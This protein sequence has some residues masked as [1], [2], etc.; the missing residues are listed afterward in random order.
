[1]SERIED[2]SQLPLSDNRNKDVCTVE[3]LIGLLDGLLDT[4]R[5]EANKMSS[6]YDFG[7]HGTAEFSMMHGQRDQ[8]LDCIVDLSNLIESNCIEKKEKENYE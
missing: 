7:S 5:A 8:L 3:G 4:W 1:M 2:S 6:T